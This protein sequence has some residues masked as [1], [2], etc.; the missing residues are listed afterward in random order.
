MIIHNWFECRNPR[1]TAKLRVF[2]FSHAGGTGGA[3]NDWSRGLPDSI[4]VFSTV[5]PG[6]GVRLRERPYRSIGP[7]VEALVPA[8]LSL[9]D[10][11]FVVFG[12]CLGALLA[13]EAVRV[14]RRRLSVEPECLFAAA[15]PAPHQIELDR[16]TR[17]VPDDVLTSQL[18]RMGG[19]SPEILANTD[20]MASL[21]PAIRADL[22]VYASYKYA[23]D[24]LLQCPVIALQGA[25]DDFVS[26]QNVEAWRELTSGPFKHVVVSGGHFFVQ[27]AAA[28]VLDWLQR[29]IPRIGGPFPG[30]PELPLAQDDAFAK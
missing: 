10:R 7:L 22:E 18:G 3:Y 8:L 25:K 29:G 19:T 6:R 15:C 30:T 20:F 5:L 24:S 16:D 28:E 13:F 14:A 17:E 1:R 2:C 9:L 12:H 26:W 11:S 27:T 4:E 21:L 23:K